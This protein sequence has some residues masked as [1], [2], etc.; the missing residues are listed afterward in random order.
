MK[1]CGVVVEYNPFHNGHLYHLNAAKRITGADCMIA[2]MSGNFLQRGEPA[3]IDKFHRAKAAI[4]QGVDLVFELP[5]PYAVQ[6]SELFAKGSIQTLH[7]AGANFVCFGSE[8]GDIEL[9][10]QAYEIRKKESARYHEVFKTYLNKGLSFPEANRRAYQEI[11]LGGDSIDYSQPN[12]ILG[13][14]YVKE[15][16]DHS[17]DLSPVTIKRKNS[18]YHDTAISGNIASATSI[19]KTLLEES[20]LS[21]EILQTIPESTAAQMNAYKQTAG[22]WHDWEHYFPLLHYRVMTMDVKELEH[23]HGVEE[24]LEH[25]IKQTARSAS[26]MSEWIS[27]IKTKRYTWT[28]IQRTFVHILTS[29]TKADIA[30]IRNIPDVPYIRVLGMN[31]KGRAYLN[32]VKKNLPVPL[33]SRIYGSPDPVLKMEEKA[34]HAYYAV[35]QPAARNTLF[36]QEQKGP[37]L[38]D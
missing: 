21:A 5:F 24:G 3:V 19:R 34:A 1:A 7:A 2:V 27:L 14:S 22:I 23:I 12:N 31:Q 30:K 9:F 16:L 28:R 20:S 17:L 25:R 32:K 35:L 37:V 18:G 6:S 38:C 36:D 11:G 26:S 8:S 33:I 29:T 4:L 15:I 13:G 10:L